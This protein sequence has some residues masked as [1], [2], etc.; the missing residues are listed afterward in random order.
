MPTAVSGGTNTDPERG[1]SDAGADGNAATDIDKIATM[2]TVMIETFGTRAL[3]LAQ[4]QVDA[5]TPDQPTVA[6]SWRQIVAVIRERSVT[7][8]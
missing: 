8:D 3:S 4:A 1:A 7:T 6:E 2:A 5:A